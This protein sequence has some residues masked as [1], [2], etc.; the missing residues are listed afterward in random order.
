M[1]APKTSSSLSSHLPL[2]GLAL[3]VDLQV[4]VKELD[5]RRLRADEGA[6]SFVTAICCPH[7]IIHAKESGDG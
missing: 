1:V 4:V 5:D 3:H 7:R 6:L 2:E